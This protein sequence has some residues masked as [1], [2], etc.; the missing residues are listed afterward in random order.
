MIIISEELFT[1]V[2]VIKKHTERLSIS[3][4][5]SF[6]SVLLLILRIIKEQSK[7]REEEN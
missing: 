5:L 3:L 4:L 2:S 6:S 1:F 7:T